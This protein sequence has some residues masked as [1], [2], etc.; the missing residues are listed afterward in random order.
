MGEISNR[1]RKRRKKVSARAEK[2][3][4]QNSK[5][6]TNDED[7][8]KLIGMSQRE[9]EVYYRNKNPR[10][11]VVKQPKPVKE[12]DKYLDSYRL[13]GKDIEHNQGRIAAANKFSREN[14][15]RPTYAESILR[16]FFDKE[17]VSYEFQ[18]IVYID[19]KLI[20][21][22]FYL[23]DFYL[24][25]YNLI[26]ELDG[27]YHDSATQFEMDKLRTQDLMK[28]GYFVLRFDNSEVN[29][30]ELLKKKILYNID[31]FKMTG[32]KCNYK[33]NLAKK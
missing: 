20:I 16:D 23:P 25:K 19:D 6:H 10:E 2:R 24:P 29:N 4:S 17:M 32:R 14:A 5:R 8:L 9:R 3:K 22:K 12:T 18:K 33:K 13:C 26:I 15:K 27:G 30:L 7:A 21:K 1:E 11:I 31:K 28:L